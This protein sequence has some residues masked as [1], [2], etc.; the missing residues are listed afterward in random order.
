MAANGRRPVRHNRVLA[1]VS[2]F[3]GWFSTELSWP[4][5]VLNGLRTAAAVRRGAHRTPEGRA[6]LAAQA[7]A[8]AAGVSFIAEGRRTTEQFESALAPYL[9]P[10]ELA[11]RP[12]SMHVGEWLPVLYGGRGRRLRTR[13]VRFP[14]HDGRTLGLD[15]YSP[16]EGA[17]P[18]A[19]LPVI[20]EVHGGGWAIGDKREQGIPLLNHLAAN[21]WV[22]FNV[23]YRLSPKVKAPT[24]LIDVKSAIAWVREHAD[25][26]GG[27]PD[28]ICITGGSA[29]GHLVAMAALTQNDPEYQP[30]FEDRDTS[31]QAA[32]PI[33]GVYDMVDEGAN[34]MP[35]FRDTFVG[36]VVIGSRYRDD[37]TPFER[38]SP[39]YRTTPDAPPMMMIAGTRDALVPIE[40][41]RPF[42]RRLSEVSE[43]AVVWVE[44]LG[45]QHA[46][47]LFPSP[48]TVRAVEYVERFLDGVRRG[49]IK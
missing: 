30:G 5:I 49:V 24:H 43:H 46:Y 6:A 16:I 37:P 44:L 25:E 38:Y 33:Y 13:D 19:K 39:L 21:G 7:V 26:Y 2:F 48:R 28:F 4:F 10:E 47:E 36:P 20:I 42:A 45:A 35:G 9:S 14:T 11:A 15:V 32:V 29:G 1:P 22:G 18:G 41:S 17:V 34:M 23:N 8:C 12:S 40:A 27:D 3:L 31:L